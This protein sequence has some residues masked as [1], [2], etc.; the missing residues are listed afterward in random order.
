MRWPRHEMTMKGIAELLRIRHG[1]I[2][3][4]GGLATQLEAR[5]HDLSGDLW[6]AQ[7]LHENPDEICCAHRDFLDAG[8]DAVI[9][10]SYQTSI[11]SLMQHLGID[12]AGAAELIVRSVGLAVRARDEGGDSD[13]LV[14]ASV[15]PYGACCADG[16]EYTGAYGIARSGDA[17]ALMSVEALAEWHRPRFELLVDSTAADV[18]AVE[19]IP[20][21]SEVSA[22]M[23]LLRTRPTAR[24]WI[25]LACT[26]GACLVSGEPVAAVAR[27][28]ARM[29]DDIGGAVQVEALGVNCTN[30]DHVD[31]V[32]HSLR[33]PNEGGWDRPVV[34]YPNSGEGWDS[35]ARSWTDPVG[36]AAKASSL[37]FARTARSWAETGGGVLVGGCCRIGPSHIQALSDALARPIAAVGLVDVLGADEHT[38]LQGKAR[39]EAVKQA[40]DPELEGVGGLFGAVSSSDE[41]ELSKPSNMCFELSAQNAWNQRDSTAEDGVA[42][43]PR[44]GGLCLQYFSAGV[45]AS[46]HGDVL[47][48]SAEF[49][50]QTLAARR[51]CCELLA[52][53]DVPLLAEADDAQFLHG[54]RVLELGAGMG[55]PGLVCARRG[56]TVVTT[57]IDIPAQIHC[58][59]C[60]AVL[61]TRQ[62]GARR[63]AV[64]SHSWGSSVAK[65]VDAAHEL[66]AG[67]DAPPAADRDARTGATGCFDLVLVAD[68]IYNPD[69]H[70]ALL[71]SIRSTLRA[72]DGAA[73][74]VTFALHGNAPNEAVLHFFELAQD[75]R[76]SFCVRPLEA[77]NQQMHSTNALTD[78]C[79]S[80]SY[81]QTYA[82]SLSLS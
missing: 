62:I 54:L 10:A 8:A 59:A 67:G 41:D 66:G 45:A 82:L 17:P 78:S 12:E 47:W 29:E 55:V 72:G 20:C 36:G 51:E 7:L 22:I 61:C 35:D 81:V 49:L 60:N 69:S 64:R 3:L 13:K 50:A 75:P 37:V 2:V 79:R 80:R 11:P 40:A 21:V 77:W 43:S 16:S 23:S 46:G 6:S 63:I 31:A 73:A 44:P 24:A 34:V 28:I 15:G 26:D 38:W 4:D 39:E 58:L 71:D 53:A 27:E 25:A 57:D 5:G 76:W 9:S 30:P 68:C 74:L 19:T 42:E 1:V 18:L 48:A 33:A 32:L 70:V 14:A 65:L 56:A 52:A